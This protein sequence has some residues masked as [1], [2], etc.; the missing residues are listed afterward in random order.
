MRDFLPPKRELRWE[1][2]ILGQH[3]TYI[4]RRERNHIVNVLNNALSAYLTNHNI[5]T[6]MAGVCESPSNAE[7]EEFQSTYSYAPVDWRK[8]YE[9]D[10]TAEVINLFKD[11][12]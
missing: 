8:A 11:G 1:V 7:I 10:E 6:T 12:A 2:R 3:D 9:Y 5:K 4:G